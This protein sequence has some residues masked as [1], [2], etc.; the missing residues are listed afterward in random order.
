M[1]MG[2]EAKIKIYKIVSYILISSIA[3]VVL[4]I[5]NHPCIFIVFSI[6]HIITIL[7]ILW[8][9][10]WLKLNE[11]N[12]FV[13]PLFISSILVPLQMFVLYGL[14]AWSGHNIDFSS[15]GFN[16]FLDISKLP[17]FIL[18]S[19]VPLA[20]IINNIHRTIQTENQIE[21]AQSQL[22][23]ATEKNK[24]D[25][26]YSH[27]KNYSDIFKTLPSF[28]LTRTPLDE[29]DSK[30][31]EI[32][33]NHPYKLY[34]KIFPKSSL[35]YGY[36]SLPDQVQSEKYINLYHNLSRKINELSNKKN[37][38]SEQMTTLKHIESSIILLCRELGISYHRES[39]LFLIE[40][41]LSKY[42][43]KTSFSDE[44]EVKE[45]IR[46][47]RNILIEL[48][49]LLDLPEGH[50]MGGSHVGDNIPRYATEPNYLLFEDILPSIQRIR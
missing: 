5:T 9:L 32:Y 25:S 30:R 17:L 48:F 24:L 22:D 31:I 37:A 28:Q 21:K 47:L 2:K 14:W 11:K 12:L 38:I 27:L 42:E 13:Q 34:K 7:S 10:N 1:K 4:F 43:I 29:K 19:S 49:S 33:I 36:N 35:N 16:N 46:G 6:T 15:H 45:M 39:H 26:Y 20:A 8:H 23:L 50:F 18:A 40:D 44:K 41:P 3:G